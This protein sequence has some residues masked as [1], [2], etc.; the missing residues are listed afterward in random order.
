MAIRTAV[1]V[2]MILFTANASVTASDHYTDKQLD[3]LASRVGKIYWINVNSQNPKPPT[4]LS[5]PAANAPSF[6]AGG[7]ESF[8]I[9]DLAGRANKD[10]YYKVKFES[11]KSTAWER[12]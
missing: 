4:F 12:R 8:E 2:W 6:S 11:V 7:N 5:A 1:I 10:P 3:A 9:T